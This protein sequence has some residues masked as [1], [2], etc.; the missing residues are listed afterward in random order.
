MVFGWDRTR[1]V[2]RFLSIAKKGIDELAVYQPGKPIEEVARELGLGDPDDFIKLASNE[3]ALGP[4]PMAVKAMKLTADQ[5]H[6]YPDGG[7]FQLRQALSEKLRVKPDQIFIGHGS[8]EILQLL[9]HVYLDER[10]NIVVSDHAFIVYRLVA[11]LFGADVISVPM[12][13]DYRHDLAAMKKAVNDNTKIVFISNPNNPTGTVVSH[14][15]IESFMADIAEHVVVVFDEAY[16][17]LLPAEEQADTLRYVR[18]NR[19]VYVLRTFSKTYGLA[20]LRIGYAIAPEEGVKLLHHVRQPF[21]VNAMA[22]AAALAALEDDA[23]VD[24]TRRSVAS[25]L[26]QLTNAFDELGLEYIPSVTN[27]IM[28][29]VGNGQQVFEALQKEQVIVRPVDVYQMPEYVRIT[30]GT[31]EENAKLIA[32]LKKVVANREAD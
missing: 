24:K 26:K 23:F 15:E 1:N 3:N 20:G 10:S 14:G 19:N 27:F 31:A 13:P 25:G 18:E 32:A 12:T 5:M 16:V 2:N 6:V 7:N 21:N 28:V 30:V 9:S 8:N 11:A 29:K 22:Q 17:E 4:S